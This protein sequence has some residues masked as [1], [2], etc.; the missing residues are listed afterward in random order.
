MDYQLKRNQRSLGVRIRVNGDGGVMVSAPVLM[1]KVMVDKVVVKHIKWIERQ[2]QKTKLH[3]QV[4]PMIDWENM[5][6]RYMGKH[7]PIRQKSDQKELVRLS[8][9]V[10]WV[11]APGKDQVTLKKTAVNWLKQQA[12]REINLRVNKWGKKMQVS[13]NKIRIAQQKSRWG[14]CSSTGT[15]SFN[16]R[17]IHFSDE[18]IDYVIIH[19]LAHVSNPD[20]SKKFWAMVERYDSK[21]KY[22]IKYL[23]R[24]RIQLE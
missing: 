6:V 24:Q 22:R 5:L 18:I 2:R 21:Y 15:L 1:P 14:S 7:Y 13:Y 10:M 3:Q 16:W 17:L 23:K 19:E 12:R 9:M 8:G 20:H 11:N 4:D